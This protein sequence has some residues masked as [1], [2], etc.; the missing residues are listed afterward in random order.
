[1]ASD[2]IV[3]SCKTGSIGKII[4]FGMNAKH[5][6]KNRCVRDPNGICKNAFNDK[7]VRDD[8]EKTCLH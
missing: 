6:N 8:L 3:L 4:D 5:E 7:V 2:R 1:M